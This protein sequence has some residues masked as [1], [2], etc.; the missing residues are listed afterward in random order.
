MLPQK[1]GIQTV[2]ARPLLIFI[3][4]SVVFKD[5]RRQPTKTRQ[6]PLKPSIHGIADRGSSKTPLGF[7]A[8]PKGAAAEIE[9]IFEIKD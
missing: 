8:L 9:A 5:T 6:K 2:P 7:A 3:R 1:N 4:T